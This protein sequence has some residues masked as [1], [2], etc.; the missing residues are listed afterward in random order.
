MLTRSL[1]ELRETV[2]ESVPAEPDAPLELP[3]VEPTD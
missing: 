2:S 1:F 3:L